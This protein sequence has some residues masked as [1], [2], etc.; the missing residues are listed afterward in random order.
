MAIATGVYVQTRGLVKLF[1]DVRAVDD[2][3]FEVPPGKI[4]ALLGPSGCGKTTTLRCI[5]GL[6]KPDG[7]EILV[8]SQPVSSVSQ[9]INLPPD[10]RDMGMVF[11]SYAIWPHMTVAQ[12]VAYPLRARG[13]KGTEMTRRV[14]EALE[15]VGLA[16]YGER[17]ATKLSGGQQQRV[18]LARAIIA[19]PRVLLFDEPLSNLDAKLRTRMRFEILRLQRE[20]GIT[21]V[22]V[23]HDQGEAMAI[24][25]ELIVMNH[26]RIEQ[27]GDARSMY[28]QPASVFVA[29][30]IGS[31]N[32][33]T[34]ILVES[35]DADGVGVIR[36][37]EGPNG[38]LR[39]RV[40]GS[41]RLGDRYTAVV[42]PEAMEVRRDRLASIGLAGEITAV[43]YLGDHLEASVASYGHDLRLKLDPRVA[44]ATGDAV[45]IVVDPSDALLLPSP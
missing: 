15:L 10:R 20:V 23:T 17:P 28:L 7:G 9:G 4:L 32:L 11:Q 26:G 24:A 43:Q 8:E 33:L 30:F 13:V 25:D 16:G 40:S 39:G 5:A 2:V 37:G 19:R 44:I 22:Y 18:A 45:S 12:N 27:R 3:S 36:L 34:G 14:D 29:D 41:P 42:R 21:S 31:A 35:P 6:E 1:G 38:L